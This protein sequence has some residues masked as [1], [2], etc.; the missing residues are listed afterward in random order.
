MLG[1]QTALKLTSQI[2][3]DLLESGQVMSD[4]LTGQNMTNPLR[5]S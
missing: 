1:Y 5:S 4:Y 2:R 3:L